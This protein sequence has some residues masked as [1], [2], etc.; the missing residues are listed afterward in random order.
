MSLKNYRV[1]SL[2]ISSSSTGW[3][4]VCGDLQSTLQFGTIMPSAKLDVAGKL[5]FFRQELKI[6]FKK[7]KPNY[8]VIEDTFLG[9]NPKVVKLLAKFGGVAEQ[10]VLEYCKVSPYIMGNTTSKSFFKVP[11]KDGLFSI[12]VDLLELPNMSFEK[13]NDMSDSIAQLIC[14]CDEILN[15]NKV[16]IER[17]YG[18]QYEV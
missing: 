4:F 6:I 13:F 15:I 5:N 3:S 1:L 7:F 2:D 10:A 17:S 18:Y 8:I 9:K 16:R 12:V 11:N 14:Y